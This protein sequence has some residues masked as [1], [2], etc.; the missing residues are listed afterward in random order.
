MVAMAPWPMAA[1]GMVGGEMAVRPPPVE[2]NPESVTYVYVHV[3]IPLD[4]QPYLFVS[5]SKTPPNLAHYMY[6]YMYINSTKT[7][8]L[9]LEYR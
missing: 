8:T 2:I 6:V 4:L 1:N 9:G 3:G 7:C 5:L